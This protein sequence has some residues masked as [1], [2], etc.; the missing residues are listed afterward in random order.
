MLLCGE[1]GETHK[2]EKETA[3]KENEYLNL[4]ERK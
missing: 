4:R 2:T 3:V 1:E